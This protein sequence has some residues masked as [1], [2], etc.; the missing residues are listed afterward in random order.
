[1]Q[2][3]TEPAICLGPI[4]NLQGSYWLLELHIGRRIKRRTFTP[5]PIPTRVID[6]VHTLA[7]AD[8]QNLALNF[9][10][11]LGNPIPNGD[12]PDDENEDNTKDLSGVEEWDNDQ[13][14]LPGVTTQD[15][16]EE[17]PGVTTVN[18]R[19]MRT[20]RAELEINSRGHITSVKPFLYLSIVN[21]NRRRRRNSGDRK[22]RR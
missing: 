5:L 22:T 11:R 6:C 20:V 17:T 18:S 4:G 13:H 12:T 8:N 21:N 14:K 1:M 10:D 2:S 15:H 3:R 19:K 16:Q 7:N 9:F